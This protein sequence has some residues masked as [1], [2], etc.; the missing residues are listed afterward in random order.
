M[1]VLVVGKHST[2]VIRA[3]PCHSERSEE[4]RSFPRRQPRRRL[5]RDW[6][7]LPR[8]VIL[9]LTFSPSFGSRDG[10]MR[11]LDGEFDGGLGSESR[12]RMKHLLV[13]SLWL[14]AA[15]FAVCPIPQHEQCY[16]GDQNCERLN[17]QEDARYRQCM[18]EERREQERQY[19]EYRENRERERER[20]HATYCQQHPDAYECK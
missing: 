14:S 17:R 3:Q 12:G 7:T 16:A 19:Q 18:E 13:L 5:A 2:L 1:G 20:Q 11:V 9:G 4:S 10:V 8:R 6:G 15:A